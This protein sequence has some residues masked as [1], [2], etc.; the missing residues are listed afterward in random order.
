VEEYSDR[1]TRFSLLIYTLNIPNFSDSSP[2]TMWSAITNFFGFNQLDNEP[3]PDPQFIA[4]MK[5]D[6]SE[7]FFGGMFIKGRPVD[8]VKIRV[9]GQ[10]VYAIISSATTISCFSQ[11]AVRELGLHEFK[12]DGGLKIPTYGGSADF[13]G[14]CK[15]AI[16][17]GEL[18]LD[19]ELLVLAQEKSPVDIIIGVDVCL[20][21]ER[22]YGH[23]FC[24]HG[25]HWQI[26]PVTLPIEQ[27]ACKF[28]K[29]P[30]FN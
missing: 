29:L 3:K 10:D 6:Q 26:G 17:L 11:K 27:R 30:D 15:V 8:C 5:A 4:R 23:S 18:Q 21:I 25:D 28:L 19:T 13:N 16:E 2:E 12:I 22:K 7:Y 1:V 14:Y 24:M 9:N 20:K